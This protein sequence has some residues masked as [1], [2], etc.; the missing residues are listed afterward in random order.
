MRKLIAKIQYSLIIYKTKAFKYK[1]LMYRKNKHIDSYELQYECRRNQQKNIAEEFFGV[2]KSSWTKISS[3]Q[4]EYFNLT[5]G[6]IAFISQV[7][8]TFIVQEL[9][10]GGHGALFVYPE[11]NGTCAEDH[12]QDSFGFVL[13]QAHEDYGVNNSDWVELTKE[14]I[15]Y[16]HTD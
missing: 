5:H 1:L 3:N 15:E 8:L 14:Q 9:C 4:A 13:R 11:N 2:S 6:Q 7:N 10:D 12:L 16:Y